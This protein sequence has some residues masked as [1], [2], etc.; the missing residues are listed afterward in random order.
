MHRAL[1]D[2]LFFEEMRKLSSA[3]ESGK[4]LR[5]SKGRG[6]ES[7]P[8]RRRPGEYITEMGKS[9]TVL[10]FW[11]K[12]WRMDPKLVFGLMTNFFFFE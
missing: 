10:G 7:P 5:N 9:I 3:H 12:F 11:L 1:D 4:F 2:V 8:R 6:A